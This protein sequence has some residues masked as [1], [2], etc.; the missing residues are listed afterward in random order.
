MGQL[1]PIGTTG[2]FAA[3]AGR[4]VTVAGRVLAIFRIGDEFFALD[5]ICPHAGGPLAKGAVSGCVVTCPWHGWQFDVSTGQ[6]C[7]NPRLT[8]PRYDVHRHGE[9]LEIE[10]PDP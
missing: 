5:A 7:L 4:E 1:V 9:Q 6:H 2:E 10:L 3:G 8:Q